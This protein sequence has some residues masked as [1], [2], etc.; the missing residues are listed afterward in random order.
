MQGVLLLNTDCTPLR[1]IPVRR[2][3]VL[4]MAG[5]AE[6][7]ADDVVAHM[8]SASETF[9][10]PAVIRLGYTVK[11]PFRKTE[12]PCTRRGIIARDNHICQFVV[13]GKACQER[14]DT[15]DHVHPK[16][17][18]GASSGWLN[19]VASCA[20]H[21]HKKGMRMLEELD[22]WELKRQPTAPRGQ[23]RLLGSR[24]DADLPESWLPFLPSAI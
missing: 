19:Q 1:V 6:P 7:M 10:V 24:H 12:V 8:H 9:E 2:A 5:R 4:L 13:N 20:K 3:V 17:L 21:N 22:G 14:A 15:V 11:I 23:M 18:G 16:A